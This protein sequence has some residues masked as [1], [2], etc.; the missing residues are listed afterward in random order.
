MKSR[1]Y[2]VSCC[3]TFCI[4]GLAYSSI[5]GPMESQTAKRGTLDH[6]VAQH[7]TTRQAKTNTGQ[8]SQPKATSLIAV[9][10]AGCEP[11]ARFKN[12]TLPVLV[13]QGYHV[14]YMDFSSWKGPPIKALPTLFFCV[15]GNKPVKVHEGFMTVEQVKKYLRKPS[16]Q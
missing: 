13:E 1:I 5:F 10:A 6:Q 11:C 15:N 9:G 12:R 8:N 7:D 2:G 16:L 3:V 4:T 14:T